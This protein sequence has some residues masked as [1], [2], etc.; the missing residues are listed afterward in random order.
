MIRL[1][2]FMVRLFFLP[3]EL[4][5]RSLTRLM[6]SRANADLI[7]RS[8]AKH[9]PPTH[10]RVMPSLDVRIPPR[11]DYGIDVPLPPPPGA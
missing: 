10:V 2:V 4:M 8:V 11:R 7:G 9:M 5:A 1:A 3:F 6:R